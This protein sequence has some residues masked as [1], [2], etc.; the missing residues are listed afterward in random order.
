M[1]N[2]V[3]V[4]EKDNF[5]VRTI[6][7]DNE[8]WFVGK[9][10]AEA[11]GYELARKAILDHVE[12]EDKE[13]LSKNQTFQNGTLEIPNRG[14]TIINESGLY[15]LVLS[16]KLPTAKEFKRWVTS[17]VLPSI[18]KTGSYQSTQISTI[19]KE[20]FT[21]REKEVDV[22]RAE[23][24]LQIANRTNIPEYKQIIDSYATEALTG[25][26]LLPLPIVEKQTY[27]AS[28]IGKILGVSANKIGKLA[29]SHNLKTEQYGKYFYDKSKYSSKEVETF[30]Y[31]NNAI[32]VFKELLI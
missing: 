26:K 11:L 17:E 12:E 22:K 7:K 5:K 31:Y 2:L 9:D 1:E 16:S 28:E 24:L 18:R 6:I 29:N 19:S 10:V 27:S 32:N 4:F 3:K 30:R 8:I 13:I 21:L 14:L 15:S 25:K 23:L 20:E